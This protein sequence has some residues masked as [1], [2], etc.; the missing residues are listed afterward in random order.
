MRICVVTSYPPN[1][2]GESTYAHSYVNALQKYL[3][4]EVSEIHVLSHKEG[5]GSDTVNRPESSKVIIYRLFKSTD[6][7]RKNFSFLKIFNAILRIRPDVVHFEYSPLPK[8]KYGGIIGEPLLILFILL[9]IVRIPFFVT[10]HSIW[11][12]DQ[13]KQRLLE[14]TKSH[15]LAKLGWYYYKTITCFFG[16][17]PKSLFLLVTKGNSELIEQF[18]N[19]YNIPRSQL[20]EE[21]HGMWWHESQF[22]KFD[23]RPQRVV[24]LG[25]ITPSKGYEYTLEAMRIVVQKLPNSSLIIAGTTIAKEG[26]EYISKLRQL[27]SAYSLDSTVSIEERYLSDEEFN[28]YVRTAGVVVLPYTRVVG[29]SGIM[30]LAISYRVP[31]IIARSGALFTEISDIVPNVPTLD[32]ESLADEIVK[33]LGSKNNYDDLL[34]RYENYFSEHDWSVVVRTIYAEFV[35]AIGVTQA[36]IRLKALDRST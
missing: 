32:H 6:P 23:K 11:L 35:K 4:E 3:R 25:V 12:P 21:L 27:T 7:I 20:K 1:I 18:S 22:E 30:T 9:R 17:L 5:N 33:A 26:K 36:D 29:A 2:G 31:I 34:R 10:L 16:R 15:L 14:L 13:A 8:G 28:E 24:C 19:T